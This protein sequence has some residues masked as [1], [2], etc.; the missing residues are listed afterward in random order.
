MLSHDDVVGI[1]AHYGDTRFDQVA[2]A[3]LHEKGKLMYV[4]TVNEVAHARSLM[5]YGDDVMITDVLLPSDLE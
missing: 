4:Y 3:R 1:C 5:A 2:L